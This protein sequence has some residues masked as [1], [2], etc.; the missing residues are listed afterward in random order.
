[1]SLYNLSGEIPSQEDVG[2]TLEDLSVGLIEELSGY[3]AEDSGVELSEDE[4]AACVSGLVNTAGVIT[5]HGLSSETIASFYNG[6]S[7]LFPAENAVKNLLL[8]VGIIRAQN[9]SFEGSGQYLVGVSPFAVPLENCAIPV[10]EYV[11]HDRSGDL[12]RE[13]R[14][15]QFA[16]DDSIG[17]TV[18]LAMNDVGA[19][20]MHSAIETYTALQ[21][22][23]GQE[24]VGRETAFVSIVSEGLSEIPLGQECAAEN[25]YDSEESREYFPG[26]AEV[27]DGVLKRLC[28]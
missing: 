11:P 6:T 20:A 10:S 26:W 8:K 25:P 19:E 18:L 7:E 1:M 12:T 2:L 3:Y 28:Q 4:L 16:I 27:M 21:M 17:K 9:G 23:A 13:L 5:S 15:G 24:D 14:G 22:D